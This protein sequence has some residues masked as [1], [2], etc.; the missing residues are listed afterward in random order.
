MTPHE[1]LRAKI[2][3]ELARRGLGAHMNNTRWAR[4]LTAMR[5]L[6]FPPPYQRKDLLQ[7]EPAPPHFDADVHYHGDWLEGIHPLNTIE[8]LKIRPRHLQHVALLVPPRLVSCEAELRHALAAIGQAYEV[9]DD[10]VWI[11]G[12]R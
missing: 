3:T 4:L 10:A 7:P 1:P 12:Y 8:W 5:G 9:D 6:S 11:F 2:H